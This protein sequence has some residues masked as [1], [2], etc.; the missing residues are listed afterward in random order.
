M[1]VCSQA[2]G[3]GFWLPGQQV[4]YRVYYVY[5]KR[6]SASQAQQK[7][8]GMGSPVP[9]CRS[10]GPNLLLSVWGSKK[11]R[12]MEFDETPWYDVT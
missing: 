9:S 7:L 3:L 10:P 4:E 2:L 8:V 6:H 5:G 12:Q 1:I 11:G